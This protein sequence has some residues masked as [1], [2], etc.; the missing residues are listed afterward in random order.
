MQA[1][2]QFPQPICELWYVRLAK[3][4]CH[5]SIEISMIEGKIVLRFLEPHIW[6]VNYCPFGK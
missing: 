1:R 6:A 4:Y 2:K 3:L 5:W